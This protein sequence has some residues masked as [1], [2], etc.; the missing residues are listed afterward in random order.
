MPKPKAGQVWPLAAIS[1]L[2]SMRRIRA[3]I[4]IAAVA[5]P[6]GNTEVRV[7]LRSTRGTMVIVTYANDETGNA[8]ASLRASSLTHVT[9]LRVVDRRPARP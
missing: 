9:G 3:H 6:A 2:L 1:Q 8:Y 5:S 7:S 4:D